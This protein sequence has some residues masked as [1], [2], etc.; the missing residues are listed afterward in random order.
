[1]IDSYTRRAALQIIKDNWDYFCEAGAARSMLDFEFY[2]V[3]GGV[4]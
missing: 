4:K 2:I 1:M 3:T